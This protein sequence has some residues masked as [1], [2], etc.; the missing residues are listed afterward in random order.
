MLIYSEYLIMQAPPHL[1]IVTFANN[2]FIT[3]TH[4]TVV[5]SKGG[6]AGRV[7][8]KSLAFSLISTGSWSFLCFCLLFP[9]F[10]C[11]R[12]LLCRFFLRL[13]VIDNKDPEK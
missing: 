4:I 3:V 1:R 8:L 11:R 7:V 2:A 5:F 13:S 10:L 6:G 9:S 12:S